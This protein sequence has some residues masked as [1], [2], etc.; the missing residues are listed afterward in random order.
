[1]ETRKAPRRERAKQRENNQS[2][3]VRNERERERRR[4]VVIVSRRGFKILPFFCCLSVRVFLCGR[5]VRGQILA[6]KKRVPLASFILLK[7]N[8]LGYFK[9]RV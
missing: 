4:R 9:I 8:C 1:M 3:T 6:A 7:Q 5:R 2:K